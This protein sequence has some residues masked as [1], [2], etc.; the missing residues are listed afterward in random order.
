MHLVAELRLI[1]NSFLSHKI[2][3]SKRFKL[4]ITSAILGI[5]CSILNILNNDII[6]TQNY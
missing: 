6:N 1:I 2:M 3:Q 4:T 5:I